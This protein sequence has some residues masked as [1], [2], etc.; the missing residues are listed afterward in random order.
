MACQGSRLVRVYCCRGA[1]DFCGCG[2]QGDVSD[3]PGCSD[4]EPNIDREGEP[5]PLPEAA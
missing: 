3:C 4:C 5:L 1:A 2:G